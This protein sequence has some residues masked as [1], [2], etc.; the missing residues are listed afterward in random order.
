MTSLTFP[1]DIFEV[2][3]ENR[4]DVELRLYGANPSGLTITGMIESTS[5][6]TFVD[7]GWKQVGTNITVSGAGGGGSGIAL[8]GLSGFGQFI[9]AKITVPT[10]G[11]AYACLSA[12]ARAL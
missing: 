4:L 6:A 2:T 7:A 11:L 8:T 3:G 10:T 9:R 1:S 12:V 5:D